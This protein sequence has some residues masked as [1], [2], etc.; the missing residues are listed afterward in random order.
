MGGRLR[1][2]TSRA[3]EIADSFADVDATPPVAFTASPA[4]PVDPFAEPRSAR[5]S[6]VKRVASIA[7]SD[8]TCFQATLAASDEDHPI[9]DLYAIHAR[10]GWALTVGLVLV[11]NPSAPTAIAQAL[12]ESKCRMVWQAQA[13]PTRAHLQRPRRRRSGGPWSGTVTAVLA[14][15]AVDVHDASSWAAAWRD[16]GCPEP[17]TLC[18]GSVGSGQFETA[19]RLSARL[20]VVCLTTTGHSATLSLAADDVLAGRLAD[21]LRVPALLIRAAGLDTVQVLMAIYGEA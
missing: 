5:M 17:P 2:V 18:P 4:I 7:V 19:V 20:V 15:L 6:G 12:T 10:Y 1:V 13:A 9:D 21:H 14:S 16:A 3:P 11:G 8:L